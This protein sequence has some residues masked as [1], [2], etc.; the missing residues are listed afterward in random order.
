MKILFNLVSAQTAPNYIA[1]KEINPDK[2]I[3]LNTNATKNHSNWLKSAINIDSEIYTIDAYD[4][5]N[6]YETVKSLVLKYKSDGE[7]ELILNFTGGT[8]IMSFASL[9]VF[10]EFKLDSIYIDSENNKIL[11][12]SVKDKFY[13]KEIGC[14]ISIKDYFKIYGQ[15]IKINPVIS[16]DNNINAKNELK[17][18]LVNNLPKYINLIAAYSREYNKNNNYFHKD[19]FF[20]N[21]ESSVQWNKSD[22]KLT[23]KFQLSGQAKIFEFFGDGKEYSKYLTGGWFEDVCFEEMKN[24][25]VFDETLMNVEIPDLKKENIKNELDIVAI[26]NDTLYIF[27]CKSGD[28]KQDFIY[29]LKSIKENYGG[30]YAKIIFLSYFPVNNANNKERIKEYNINLILF[31]YLNQFLSEI[32]NPEYKKNI[33]L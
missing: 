11:Y 33:N 14:K 6:I 16:I 18:F 29:K 1:V 31:K 7:N 2:I 19:Q 24:S 9:N 5:V 30:T 32:V 4:Y 23:V 22:K 21:K 28:I 26:K 3:Y 27:E 8:K 25:K 20:K 13:Q 12:F 15:D 10:N 17:V